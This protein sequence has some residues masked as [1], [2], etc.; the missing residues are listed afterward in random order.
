[1]KIAAIEEKQSELKFIEDTKAAK[2]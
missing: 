1:M 2:K